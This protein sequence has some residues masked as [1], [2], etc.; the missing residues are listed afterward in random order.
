MGCDCSCIG[1]QTIIKR[2]KGMCDI[3]EEE[4]RLDYSLTLL[5]C[6]SM[7]FRSRD[8]VATCLTD[9]PCFAMFEIICHHGA[10]SQEAFL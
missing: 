7:L 3:V 9:Q 8:G 4:T 6:L 10:Y 2:V 1:I 5:I